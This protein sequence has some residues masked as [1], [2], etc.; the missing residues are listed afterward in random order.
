MVAAGMCLAVLALGPVAEPVLSA[1]GRGMVP[2]VPAAGS[3]CRCKG[4]P[5][6]CHCYRSLT[7]PA[8]SA[9]G[10]HAR[11][12]C[13]SRLSHGPETSISDPYLSLLVV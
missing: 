10:S 5:H 2:V 3:S 11:H 1:D 4:S 6:F 13:R 8:P 7:I 12:R 9:A